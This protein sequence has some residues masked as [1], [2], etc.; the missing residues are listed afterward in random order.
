MIRRPP[1][2]TLCPYTT[3]FRSG[4]IQPDG[5]SAGA[6][7]G[8]AGGIT[9]GGSKDLRGPWGAATLGPPREFS[10]KI[11]L[12]VG[13]GIAAYKSAELARM[14]MQQGHEVGRAAPKAAATTNASATKRRRHGRRARRGRGISGT[15]F[16]EGSSRGEIGRAH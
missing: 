9:R 10:M 2:S 7:A 13:G 8:R 5:N 11:I 16:T 4:E 14:L 12:G 6:E 3:L 1:R 15:P